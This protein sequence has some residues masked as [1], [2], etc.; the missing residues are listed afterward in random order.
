MS[1]DNQD[2]RDDNQ[3]SRE[4]N[5][6]SRDDNQDIWD[7]FDLDDFRIFWSIICVNLSSASDFVIRG[8]TCESPNL[9][10]HLRISIFPPNMMELLQ[11]TLVPLA[12]AI[13]HPRDRTSPPSTLEQRFNL[14]SPL[15]ERVMEQLQLVPQM[16]F[17]IDE[18]IDDANVFLITW[19]RLVSDAP[20]DLLIYGRPVFS[21]SCAQQARRH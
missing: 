17:M 12:E 11:N 5:Q 21:E 3:D 15:V 9:S 6:Y 8:K 2:R 18:C 14:I 19:Y 7:G 4:D 10:H 20:L 1:E 13:R 16:Q